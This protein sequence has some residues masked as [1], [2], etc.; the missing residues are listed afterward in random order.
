MAASAWIKLIGVCSCLAFG[1]GN[2]VAQR[3]TDSPSIS[4]P[5]PHAG[6]KVP[7]G[8]GSATLPSSKGANTAQASPGGNCNADALV[9][10]AEYCFEA[11]RAGYSDLF[12]GSCNKS[13][14]KTEA[15]FFACQSHNE[16]A[17]RNYSSCSPE[18]QLDLVRSAGRSRHVY[19]NLFACGF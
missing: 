4:S 12:D 3:A 15:G 2:A 6:E 16:G 13:R 9:K 7:P 10:D 14:D 5:Y 19:A 1:A 18:Q 11:N 8:G 17:R